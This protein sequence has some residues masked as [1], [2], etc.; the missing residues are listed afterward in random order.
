MTQVRTD[1]PYKVTVIENLWVPLPDGTRLAAKVW[2]PEEAGPVPAVLEYIPYRKRDGT[3]TRDQGLHMY[4]AG[5]GYAS[6]RLD[7]RG[8]GDSDGLLSDEYT[9]Q[10]QQD[11]RPPQQPAPISGELPSPGPWWSGPQRPEPGR[12]GGR[13]G[14]EQLGLAGGLGC[15]RYVVGPGRGHVRVRPAESA[16]TPSPGRV[17]G[18]QPRH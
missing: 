4:L 13:A 12:T 11:G 18:S 1:F 2:L 9:E 14:L 16:R 15:R 3:R 6:I 10:E 8:C 7:I 5:H 17:H